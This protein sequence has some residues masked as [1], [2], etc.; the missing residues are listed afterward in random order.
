MQITRET[1]P[2]VQSARG[3]LA[4]LALSAAAYASPQGAPAEEDKGPGWSFTLA[5]YFWATGFDGD[6]T[7][8]GQEIEG[9]GSSSGLPREFALSG[10]LGHFEARHGPWAFALSP[11]YLHVEAD[12]DDTPPTDSDIVIEGAIVEGFATRALGRG[13]QALAGVRTYALDTE[14]DVTIGGVAQPELD[15]DKSWLDPIV[16]VRFEPVLSER[17]TMSARADVGGFGLG[18]D[19]SWNASLNAGYRLS[20]YARVFL[21]YRVLDF[22]FA[23]GSGSD[24]V[25]YDVRFSGPLVGVAFDL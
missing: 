10:F 21:G 19:L 1:V 22:D 13:W 3:L 14:V 7:L 18:S 9:D 15:A 16:G 25:E 8:D 2:V 4:L 12:G 6:L 20:S 17:W 5:P 24:R 23:D 11:V